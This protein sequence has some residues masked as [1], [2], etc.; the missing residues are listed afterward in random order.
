MYKFKNNFELIKKMAIVDLKRKFKASILSYFWLIIQPLMMIFMY[1]FAFS[2]AGQT[3]SILINDVKYNW[4]AWVL[5]GCFS[6]SYFADIMVYGPSVLRTYFWMIKNYGVKPIIILIFTNISKL[7][8]GLISI[9]LA[10]I[11]TI[12]VNATDSDPN[13]VPFSAKSLEVFIYIF[14][15]ILLMFLYSYAFSNLYLISK[16]IQNIVVLLPMVLSWLSA[17]FIPPNP[18]NGNAIVNIFLEINPIYFLINGLRGSMLGYGNLFIFDAYYH[19]YSL[20]S[21]FGFVILFFSIGII[22]DNKKFK[23]FI[24]DVVV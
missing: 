2:S 3:N 17:V 16:D 23:R 13:T 20:V 21:Y 9:F 12:I 14:F 7:I 8:V 1:W 18:E 19:W 11:I 24:L 10:W 22:L 6:W 5:I 4:L 15:M